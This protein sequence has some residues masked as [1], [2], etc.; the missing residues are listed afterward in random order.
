MSNAGIW[1]C[2]VKSSFKTSSQGS[3]PPRPL[4]SHTTASQ[5]CL[6]KPRGIAVPS[7][8]RQQMFVSLGSQQKSDI[9]TAYWALLLIWQIHCPAWLRLKVCCQEIWINEIWKKCMHKLQPES[10]VSK[11]P[12]V[13]CKKAWDTTQKQEGFS[14]GTKLS[15]SAPCLHWG[16]MLKRFIPAS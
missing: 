6:Q 16:M 9:K 1:L 4:Q 5:N 2:R 10:Q 12:R 15:L 8:Q 14:N 3:K 13:T 7:A 11:Q